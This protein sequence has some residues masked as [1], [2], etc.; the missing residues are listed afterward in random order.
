MPGRCQGIPCLRP[1]RSE[2]IY[3]TSYNRNLEWSI[4]YH[5]VNQNLPDIDTMNSIAQITT[6]FFVDIMYVKLAARAI[7]LRSTLYFEDCTA[8][9][10]YISFK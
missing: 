2:Y 4:L 3:S 10:G 6:K 8:V 5:I 9:Y 7:Y 1:L